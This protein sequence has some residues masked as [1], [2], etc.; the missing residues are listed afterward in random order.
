MIPIIN[1][2]LFENPFYTVKPINQPTAQ[3]SYVDFVW[4]PPTNSSNFGTITPSIMSKTINVKKLVIPI[5]PYLNYKIEPLY[6]Y[7]LIK[8]EINKDFFSVVTNLGE[9]HRKLDLK[10]D[11]I[12]RDIKKTNKNV[13]RV[14]ISRLNMTSSYIATQSRIGPA[15]WFTANSKTY[16]YILSHLQD[17]V[18]T[19]NQDMIPMIGTTP[20]I[21]NDSIDDDIILVGR[22]NKI[23]SSGVHCFI[24]TNEQKSI[25]FQE[26]MNTGFYN[27]DLVMY[28]AME[29]IGNSSYK[30]YMK[31]NTETLAY[32][33]YKKLKRIESL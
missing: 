29:D 23:D 5:D 6:L 30:Q 33:R 3:V 28:Y 20:F 11:I 13:G 12:I 25:E 8:N 27:K 32:E 9:Q 14:I 22:K 21:I 17:E 16:N 19:Y 31:I 15:H 7:N 2:D 1:A 10:F 18:L 24:L 26:I 4:A